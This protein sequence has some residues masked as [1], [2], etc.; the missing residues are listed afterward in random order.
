MHYPNIDIHD[1]VWTTIVSDD[2]DIEYEVVGSG[3]ITTEEII[4]QESPDS[5]QEMFDDHEQEQSI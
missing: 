4:T 5:P 3:V 2:A 1:E